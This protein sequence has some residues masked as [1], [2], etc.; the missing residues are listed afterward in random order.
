MKAVVAPFDDFHLPRIAQ[1]VGKTNQFNLTTRRHGMSHLQA[2]IEDADCVHFYLRLRD[3]FADHGLVSLM[4]ALRRGQT[5]DIDTGLMSCRVL[6]RTVEA[7][8]L[9]YLFERAAALK[10]TAVQGTYIPT[11]KNAMA[12]DVFAKF[13]FKL[14]EDGGGSSVWKYDLVDSPPIK[15]EFIEVVQSWEGPDDSAE[16]T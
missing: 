12:K 14:V 7:T 4:I 6:G 1:L 13:G 2:F 16:T 8:M 10:C 9:Q 3:R 5:L 15:N 11:A